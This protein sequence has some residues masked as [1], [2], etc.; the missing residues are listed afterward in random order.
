MDFDHLIQ[1]NE[2]KYA[3]KTPPQEVRRLRCELDRD[4]LRPADRLS[5]I[6]MTKLIV[7]YDI[8]RRLRLLA[9]GHDEP[10]TARHDIDCDFLLCCV[11]HRKTS[12]NESRY[13]NVPIAA[14]AQRHRGTKLPEV[15][16][17]DQWYGDSWRTPD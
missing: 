3:M 13:K 4:Q 11:L 8:D 10:V 5:R 1:I 17:A 7:G 16:L 2:S 14:Q 12:H 6:W 15:W 9:A